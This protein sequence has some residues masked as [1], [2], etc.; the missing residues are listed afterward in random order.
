[1]MIDDVENG[2]FYQLR[3]EERRRYRE[4]RFVRE[5]DLSF[6][7][8]VDGPGKAEILQ[9]VEEFFSE[10]YTTSVELLEE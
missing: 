2:R 1:M 8:G 5:D 4:E 7:D 9:L 3:L 6:F 10:E